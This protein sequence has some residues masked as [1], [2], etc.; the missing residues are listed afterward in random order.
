MKENQNIL[1]TSGIETSIRSL[2]NY[3]KENNINPNP[4]KNTISDEEAKKLIDTNKSVRQ[5]LEIL[6]EKNLNISKDRISRLLNEKKANCPSCEN[7][8]SILQDNCP[9]CANIDSILQDNCPSCA[10]I[11]SIYEDKLN[12]EK[13]N[14]PSCA[15]ID[16][17]YEKE[18]TFNNCPSCANI[19]S[20]YE[21]NKDKLKNDSE[22]PQKK[23]I[24]KREELNELKNKLT[25]DGIT[26]DFLGIHNYTKDIEVRMISSNNQDRFESMF[27]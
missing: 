4:K 12:I 24:S 14:C 10:N 20:I 21:D 1:K 26:K 7:I 8:D 16:S 25:L 18:L 27:I 22:I 13:R 19:D 3:C 23:K 5:N 9:S 6:K 15:N 17:I 11:D 2:Y